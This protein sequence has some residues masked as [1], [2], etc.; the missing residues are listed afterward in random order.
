MSVYQKLSPYLFRFDAERLHCLAE[1]TLKHFVPLPLVQDCVV[2]QHCVFDESLHV[3]V[4]GMNFYN[5]VGLAAG[6]DKNA[7]MIKGLS[8]LGFGF[9]E[10]G[11]IT[12][13]PQ[14]G[15]AKPRL[16]R[17][18]EEKSLQ[19]AMGF[20]NDGSSKVAAR[21]K[22]LYPYSIP[23]GI[24]VGKNKVIA[25]SDSLKNYENVLLDCLEVGDYFVFNLSSPN[26]P[27]LRELQNVT[28]VQ[29]LF[30][31][32]RSH[33]NKPLFLKISP[34]MKKDEMLKLVEMSIKSGASGL[35]ATNTTIDYSLIAGAKD[36][37]G[38]SGGALKEKSK[39][40]LKI[41]SEAFFG[42]IAIISVGGIDNAQE[43]Y[44]R[45]RLGASLVQVYSGLVFRG[46]R[47]CREINEGLLELLKQDGFSTIADII[48][49][50]IAHQ[51]KRR[52][53]KPKNTQAE[54]REVV[55]APKKRGR[56]PKS[57]MST[58]STSSQVVQKDSTSKVR[59]TKT[60]QD[61]SVNVQANNEIAQAPIPTKEEPSS[62][63][64]EDD[65]SVSSLPKD[66]Q[67][68][69]KE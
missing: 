32:A 19:N 15:N 26:T 5:P 44:E 38:I 55:A 33:T 49:Y 69:S 61:R 43:V 30:E 52:G 48:G 24:N 4:A 31:M 10:I 58:E 14:E 9:L 12:Q 64:L 42:K 46:P 50:D 22:G 2:S 7:T 8:A 62:N 54:V 34:D 51:P 63:I 3:Q 17:Y 68:D 29:E 20:N 16:F 41:L 59:N 6:F 60:K 56:K 36:F 23:L 35:I 57:A 67:K 1:W 13:N 45:L 65:K 47:L 18:E 40:V 53:R 66:V 39:E 28:F 37:G 11:T 25:Q 27:K 21:L